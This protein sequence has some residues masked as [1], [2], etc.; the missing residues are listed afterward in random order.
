MSVTEFSLTIKKNALGRTITNPIVR[1]LVVGYASGAT[2]GELLNIKTINES[3]IST[4][5]NGQGVEAVRMCLDEG[6]LSVD[7]MPIALDTTNTASKSTFVNAGNLLGA[8]VGTQAPA[9]AGTSL[10]DYRI[11]V[12]VLNFATTTVTF[13]YSLDDGETWIKTTSA[14]TGASTTSLYANNAA[15]IDTGLTI[16]FPI[17]TYV[18]GDVWNGYAFAAAI[19]SDDLT[20]AAGKAFDVI[21]K[22]GKKYTH[23]YFASCVHKGVPVSGTSGSVA[24]AANITAQQV[25]IAAISTGMTYLAGIGIPAVALI[26]MPRRMPI[27]HDTDTFHRDELD[28]AFQ[29]AVKTTVT[30]QNERLLISDGRFLIS[31]PIQSVKFWRPGVYKAMQRIIRYNNPAISLYTDEPIDLVIPNQNIRFRSED[32]TSIL[33]LGSTYDESRAVNTWGGT[34]GAISNQGFLAAYTSGFAKS[35]KTLQF[36]AANTHC[37]SSNDFFEYLYLSQFNELQNVINAELYKFRGKLLSTKQDGSGALT[38]NQADAIEKSVQYV[39]DT[40]LVKPGYITP[41][42]TGM[43]VITVNRTWN[44]VSTN[45]LRYSFKMW[46]GALVKTFNGVGSLSL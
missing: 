20:T 42:P 5:G 38:E 18:A 6:L 30:T 39:V 43:S 46:V 22:N 37:D 15:T 36:L 28:V 24:N 31:S 1:P 10:D 32:M 34:F 12:E 40:L 16:N 41:I 33:S 11:R 8:T 19:K 44:V 9:L 7:I 25:Y 3:N 13:R 35:N 26:S 4:L 23:I 45:E 14:S 27:N 21:Q 2:S 29:T 17:G